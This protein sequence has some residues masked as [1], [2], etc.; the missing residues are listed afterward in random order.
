MGIASR[1][2]IIVESVSLA[3]LKPDPRN[4]RR[5]TPRNIGMI[6]QS[7]GEI[8]AA[9]SIVIDENGVVLAG[10]GVVEAAADAGIERVQIV[11]ADGETIIAVCRSGLTSEQKTRLSLY[12]NRAGELSDWEPLELAMLQEE[13]FDFSAM[14]TDKEMVGILGDAADELLERDAAPMAPEYPY[15]PDAI[16][17][18][19]N[20]WGV[21]LLDT[22]LQALAVE[23]PL[24][25][26][27]SGAGA[28]KRKIGGTWHFYTSDD[29][30]EALWRDP[31]PVVLSGCAAAVEPNFTV[32]LDTPRAF[33]LWCVYRKRWIARYWQ[34]EGVRVLVDLNVPAEYADLTFLGVPKEWRAYITR[35]YGDRM[36]AT[37]NEW[38]AA[39]EHHGDDDIL[40]TVYGGG[41]AVK[42]MCADRGWNWFAEQADR[43]KGKIDG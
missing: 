1:G 30:F 4:A 34:S 29:R 42:Q 8:G 17:P 12:D 3:D 43:Q 19:D 9:R 27:G 22:R 5:H 26:W 32:S 33:A 10:N 13:G 21:P 37:V 31:M 36:E 39:C 15:V 14:F 16:F 6:R 23:L 11:D 2:A 20:E 35:G 25:R 18:S 7:L 40:L 41:K 28:R 38:R 24:E